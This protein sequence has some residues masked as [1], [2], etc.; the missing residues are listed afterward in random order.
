MVLLWMVTQ[1]LWSG[2]ELVLLLPTGLHGLTVDL[3]LRQLCHVS[4]HC[5]VMGQTYYSILPPFII[6]CVS[7]CQCVV[8]NID[9]LCTWELKEL[10]SAYKKLNSDSGYSLRSLQLA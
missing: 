6:S 2:R 8:F 7:I 3:A 4:V 9:V 5:I 1:L 10:L